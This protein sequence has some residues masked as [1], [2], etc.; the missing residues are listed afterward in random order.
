MS[1]LG[2]G[3]E[4]NFRRTEK[5]GSGASIMPPLCLVAGVLGGGRVHYCNPI[6]QAAGGQIQFGYRHYLEGQGNLVRVLLTPI[7][8]IATLGIHDCIHLL[9][10][11]E[12]PSRDLLRTSE[13]YFE[14]QGRYGRF[15][16]IRG[17]SC[18][19]GIPIIRIIVVWGL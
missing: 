5:Q 14:V 8:H 9:S 2:L 15:L 1:G 6:F 7:N 12:P 3:C 18:G 16:K 13:P 19:A 17:T 4:Q 11:P 10:P